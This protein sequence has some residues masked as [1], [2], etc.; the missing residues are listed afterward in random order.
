[1][2]PVLTSVFTPPDVMRTPVAMAP[3]PYAA[4]RIV[5]ALAT[6]TEPYGAAA[7]TPVAAAWSASAI[8]VMSPALVTA[9]PKPPNTPAP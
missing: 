5:P 3:G 7:N 9:A 4:A 8:A 2:V 1:M 6:S